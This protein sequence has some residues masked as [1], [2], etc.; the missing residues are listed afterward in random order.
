M[1]VRK[2]L[3]YLRSDW[4]L[5]LGILFIFLLTH[6]YQYGWDDQHLEIPLLK[7]LID[8]SLYQGDYYVESLKRNFISFFYPLLA[9]FITLEQIP[10][11]YFVLFLVSRYFFFFWAYRIWLL[12]SGNRTTA[13]LCTLSFIL[14]SRIPEFLYRTFSHQ[15]F[16]LAVIFAGIYF[17]YNNRIILAAAILGAAA[18]L[19]ALYSLYPMGFLAFYLLLSH[20]RYGWRIFL[21]SCGTFAICALPVVIWTLHSKIVAAPGSPPAASDWLALLWA[22]APQVFI[23]QGIPFQKM[24]SHWQMAL[25][26]IQPYFMLTALYI[27]NFFHNPEFRKDGKARAVAATVLLAL[28]L[29]YVATYIFPL[30]FVLIL[31][32]LRTLQFLHFFLIGYT[33]ILLIS[34]LRTQP[35]WFGLAMTVL[36][37]MLRLDG[38]LAGCAALGMTAV[39][40]LKDCKPVERHKSIFIIAAGL[41]VAAGGLTGLFYTM[42]ITELKASV[43]NKALIMVV[44]I[45]LA[46]LLIRLLRFRSLLIPQITLLW[47]PFLV[48]TGTYIQ[49]HINHVKTIKQGTGFWAL[50]AQWEDMQ[51]Y[52][53]DNTPKEALLL[54]PYDMKMGGFR[55]FSDRGIVASERDGGVIGFDYQAAEQ[56]RQRIADIQEFKIISTEPKNSAVLNAIL[57]YH[58]H[59][60]VF[61]NYSAP[62]EDQPIFKK[63]YQNRYFSLFEV[64]PAIFNKP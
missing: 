45:S 52:V 29:T 30:K 50:R 33:V 48:M 42:L 57:K 41:L 43:L 21:K 55:I 13:F 35:L 1:P 6:G 51:H 60:I 4:I 59:Y 23:F 12:I 14:L 63:I 47:I 37:G 7:G 40:F 28:I 61:M 46:F 16:V 8:P 44:T 17:F 27:L 15:E 24:I 10:A 26:V 2:Y 31:N 20:R 9:Q 11:A 3:P 19:H 53:R 32:L 22:T 58:A 62:A 5:A 49:F 56:W 18:N 54:V 36:F 39:L 25:V 34:I 64:T 38:L